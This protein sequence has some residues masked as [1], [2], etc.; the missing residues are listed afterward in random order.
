M[1]RKNKCK[2]SGFSINL[3]VITLVFLVIA[4]CVRAVM[5]PDYDDG[6]TH[7]ITTDPGCSIQVSNGTT[8]NISATISGDVTV[9]GTDPEDPDKAS[10]VN[11][12]N[13]SNIAGKVIAENGSIVNM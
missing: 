13:K 1:E 10:T 3:C 6:G 4:P 5:P 2:K 11:L 12:L 8:V 7:N 9:S